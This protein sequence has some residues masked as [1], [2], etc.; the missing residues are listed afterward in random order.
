MSDYK[1]L[2]NYGSIKENIPNKLIS[3][4]QLKIRVQINKKVSIENQKY[5]LRSDNLNSHILFKVTEV[6]QI[7]FEA[8]ESLNVS[9]IIESLSLNMR[10]RILESFPIRAV[11]KNSVSLK[12]FNYFTSKNFLLTH[13][14]GDNQ[15]LYL[16]FEMSAME[17]VQ[18][19]REQ[20]G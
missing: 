17:L 4:L 8:E 20:I 16:L 12:A 19:F 2:F 15:F 18:L 5:L 14:E 6:D 10:V 7:K 11:I 1:R 9:I 13:F 3:K